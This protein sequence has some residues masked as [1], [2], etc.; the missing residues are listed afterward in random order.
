VPAPGVPGDFFYVK[1]EDFTSGP[2][3]TDVPPPAPIAG[4]GKEPLVAYI[5]TSHLTVLTS[6][7]ARVREGVGTTRYAVYYRP[8]KSW[9]LVTSPVG[10]TDLRV[11]GV[12]LAGTVSRDAPEASPG[13]STTSGNAQ[14]RAAFTSRIEIFQMQSTGRLVLY[15][16][17]TRRQFEVAT[18]HPD[19]EVLAVVDNQLYYRVENALYQGTLVEAGI[20]STR[21]LMRDPAIADVHWLFPSR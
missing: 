17:R 10:R 5:N 2:M 8:A 12:W 3:R 4:S 11:V 21:L 6:K 16:P 20:S 9:H 13:A 15:N 19:S 7:R 1:A 14:A 18:P